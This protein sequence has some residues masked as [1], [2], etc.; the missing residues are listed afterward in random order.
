MPAVVA[1][2]VA[3]G[4]ERMICIGTDLESSHRAVEL[5]A[6]H[7]EVWATV[8]LHPHNAS[9]FDEEWDGIA[10]LANADRVV[11][12]GES[13]FDLHYLHSPPDAQDA[14]FRAH[15]ALAKETG[16][17]LVIHTREAWDDTFSVLADEGV[18]ERTVFHCFTGGRAEAE[19]AVAL[20][21]WLSFSGIVTFE[22]AGDV[23][24]AA[25]AA[26]AGRLLVE[27]DSPYLTPVPRRGKTNEPAYVVHVGEGVASAR[28]E[29]AERVAEITHA[30]TDEAFPPA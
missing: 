25:A 2:A 17:T 24:A 30:N 20:G 3:A 4:V 12:V 26:P 13:G 27:T 15:V 14:A 22:R 18:P 6:T 5:A 16:R 23:R 28:G 29:P 19:R 10:E 1:R 21:A 9:R 7:S 11:G 8:G